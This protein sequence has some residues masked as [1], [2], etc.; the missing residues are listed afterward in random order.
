MLMRPQDLYHTTGAPKRGYGPALWF[1][2]LCWGVHGSDPPNLVLP[3]WE[4]A[5]VKAVG[6]SG[7]SYSS[8]S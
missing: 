3:A 6:T 1:P 2:P 5:G 4:G 8:A 7:E